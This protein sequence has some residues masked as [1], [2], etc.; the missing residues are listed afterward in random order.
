MWT[1]F[2]HGAAMSAALLALTVAAHAESASHGTGHGTVAAAANESHGA[3]AAAS[4]RGSAGTK[5]PAGGHGSSSWAY[6][7]PNGPAQWGRLQAKFAACGEGSTQSPINLTADHAAGSSAGDIAFSYRPTPLR[8]LNNGH[9]VQVNYDGGSTITVE[10]KTFELLQ[11]H[12]HSPSEHAIDGKLAD[13]E[14]HLVHRNADGQLAVIGVL[15]NIGD[16]NL[17]LREVWQ[18]MPKGAAP[19]R[20][21]E[22][23]V[24]NARDF[25]PHDATYYRYMGSL[26]TPPCSEG[27]NWFVMAQPIEVSR[28]QV[29]QFV[30]VIGANNRPLQEVKNRL[31]LAPRANN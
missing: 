20:D 7:G 19:E 25:L 8:L 28:E 16:E 2:K 22:R 26:T 24:V 17:A 4:T 23:N 5:A 13:M 15:M 10:G 29:A 31:V 1:P 18:N 6:S 21:F 9:T 3:T 27:V 14:V 11:L 12:F 30:G